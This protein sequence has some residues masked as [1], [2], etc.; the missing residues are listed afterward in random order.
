MM[1]SVLAIP[2]TGSDSCPAS[3]QDA[4]AYGRRSAG[5]AALGT[6]RRPAG[7]AATTATACWWT[8][9]SRTLNF[10]S[11]ADSFDPSEMSLEKI[12]DEMGQVSAC[13]TQYFILIN[14]ITK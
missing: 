13:S 5:W 14:I 11:R 10:V 12:G 3:G 8:A 1:T 4:A 6:D 2:V 7:C 9:R